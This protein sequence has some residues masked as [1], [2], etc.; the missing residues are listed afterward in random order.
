MKAI[1]LSAGQGKR[2]LPLT[3]DRPKCTIPLHGRSI[4]EWQI[5]ELIK[6]GIRPI[7][8][9]VGFEASTVE[10]VLATHSSRHAIHTLYNPFYALADNL[11]SCWTARNEMTEDFILLNGDTVFETAILKRVLQ[12][13]AAPITLVTDEK[14]Q[15]DADDM[16]VIVRGTQLLRIGKKLALEKVNGESIGMI[17]FQDEGPRMFCSTIEQRIRQP[18]SL[19]QWYLSL[20]DELATQGHVSTVSINGLTWAEID[21]PED[22]HYAETRLK[23]HIPKP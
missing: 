3:Q 8:V 19:K 6:L 1:I 20:I 7:H 23:P 16:K 5:D 21:N 4:L 18:E 11:I 12:A 22:L 14:P 13:P 9:V 10:Q 15:Y 2:L 17:R